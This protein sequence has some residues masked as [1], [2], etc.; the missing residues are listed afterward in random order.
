[1][2]LRNWRKNLE[3]LGLEFWLPLPLIGG[4][5]WVTTAWSTETILK[6]SP[7]ISGPVQADTLPEVEIALKVKLISIEVKIFKERGFTTVDVDVSDSTLKE[8]EFDF[9]VTDL[10]EVE[11]EIAR[12]LN[13]SPEEIRTLV[14]Y[15]IN[16]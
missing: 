4:L 3:I 7:N 16:E 2:N 15:Q 8:L 1:M 10:A 6:S 12:T 5:F 13:L 11:T 14:R 9:P